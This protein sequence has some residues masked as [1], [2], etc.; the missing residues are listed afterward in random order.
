MKRQFLMHKKACPQSLSI[1]RSWKTKSNQTLTQ[2]HRESHPC[3]IY[4]KNL[5]TPIP[6]SITRN[7]AVNMLLANALAKHLTALKHKS[8]TLYYFCYSCLILLY[9]YPIVPLSKINITFP[10]SQQGRC[11]GLMVSVLVHGL[12]GPGSS[13][14]LN[15][16]SASLHPGV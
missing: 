14:T 15:S 10:P 9:I 3:R 11:D 2:R 13:K 7:Q 5:I 1:T 12:S 16:H 4:V 8:T 6:H